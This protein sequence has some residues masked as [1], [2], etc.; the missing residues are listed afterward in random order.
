MKNC[1]KSLFRLV[2]FVFAVTFFSYLTF[3]QSS[4]VEIKLLRAAQSLYQEGQHLEAEK[5]CLKL[6]ETNNNYY[7]AYNVLGVI[8][9]QRGGA[10]Q[11]AIGYFNASLSIKPDQPEV[12]S[13]IAS[14][15]HSLSNVDVA[16]SY[17]EEGLTYAPDNYS[18]NYS[19]GVSYF[20]A[21]HDSQ[22]AAKYLDKA[23]ELDSR[24]PMLLY[25]NGLAHLFNQDEVLVLEF[26]T[27]LRQ[28]KSEYYADQLEE[29]MRRRQG[30]E[31]KQVQQSSYRDLYGPA[32]LAYHP[33]VFEQKVSQFG[34][35]AGTVSTRNQ[36]S[37]TYSNPTV[38]VQGKG[39]VT[40]E[41]RY[42]TPE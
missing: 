25:I 7:P 38:K 4:N 18:L 42:Q 11:L 36:G 31:Q 28:L 3:A 5:I 14:L 22:K 35:E 24:Q 17:L 10:E 12:Y 9:A 26:I 15:Y 6:I 34:N 19:L 29:A 16:I 8:C 20:L 40:L 41:Q 32:P 1:S 30:V 27:K 23:Y 21:K 33:P 2:F 39:T 13:H 37:M